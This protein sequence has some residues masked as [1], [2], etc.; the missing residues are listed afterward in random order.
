MK[1]FDRQIPEGF[2]GVKQTVRTIA[3][4][5]WIGSGRPKLRRLARGIDTSSPHTTIRDMYALARKVVRYELDPLGVEQ[6]QGI[7][8]LLSR[9]RGDCDDYSVFLGALGMALNFPVRLSVVRKKGRRRFHHVF[10][11]FFINREWRPIDATTE[12]PPGVY[13]AGIAKTVTFPVLV[14]RQ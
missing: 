12:N 7:D 3:A 1:R 8:A 5:A 4:L 10:P 9:R 14:G 2:E 11:E 13:P 6:V